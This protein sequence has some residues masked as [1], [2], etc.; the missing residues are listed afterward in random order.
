M[1]A[2]AAAGAHAA[3]PTGGGIAAIFPHRRSGLL[4]SSALTIAPSIHPIRQPPAHTEES[5]MNPETRYGI[6][7]QENRHVDVR[8]A[9]AD[10]ATRRGARWV[11]VALV[12]VLLATPLL[13]Y[14]GPDVMYPA[15][16]V[17]A[18]EALEGHLSL[19]AYAAPASDEPAEL[20]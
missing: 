9:N 18:D 11:V 12:T 8:D 2:G 16:P 6:W 7:L 5:A 10:P 14:K 4:H 20:Q 13:L 15:A 3:E 17:I 19:H 1:A